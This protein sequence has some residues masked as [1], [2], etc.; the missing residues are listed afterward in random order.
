MVGVPWPAWR[1][2]LVSSFLD[3][4]VVGDPAPSM[5]LP[6]CRFL[7]ARLNVPQYSPLAL[8]AADEVI[9]DSHKGVRLAKPSHPARDGGLRSCAW[10]KKGPSGPGIQR[11]PMEIRGSAPHVSR[12]VA[13]IQT[14]GDKPRCEPFHPCRHGRTLA[15]Q[16]PHEVSASD[17]HRR[18]TRSSTVDE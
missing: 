11:N 7:T 12:N 4:A 6:S 1:S 18:S 16:T 9:N 17:E 15:G 5:G 14:P 8:P 13:L 3:Q 2:T 10:T